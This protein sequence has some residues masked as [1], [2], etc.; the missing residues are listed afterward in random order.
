ML[1]AIDV[2]VLRFRV[3]SIARGDLLPDSVKRVLLGVKR[4][5]K[6][7]IERESEWEIDRKAEVD[8]ETE[9]EKG[10]QTHCK[11]SFL[12]ARARSSLARSPLFSSR[13]SSARYRGEFD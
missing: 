9:S 11:S 7:Q 12:P 8:R 5:H 2:S 4:S 10:K 13:R 6:S 1:C 3:A